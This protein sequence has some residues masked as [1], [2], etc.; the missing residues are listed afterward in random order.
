MMLL[1]SNGHFFVLYPCI[2]ICG[3]LAMYLFVLLLISAAATFACRPCELHSIQGALSI[4]I[5]F[6]I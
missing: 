2:E 4:Y 6:R 5:A 1:V 3:L